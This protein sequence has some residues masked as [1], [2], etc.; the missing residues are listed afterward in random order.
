MTSGPFYCW[1][2]L[3]LKLQI[4]LCYFSFLVMAILCYVAKNSLRGTLIN[5]HVQ[6]LNR[7]LTDWLLACCP[8]DDLLPDWW[9][10]AQLVTCCPTD[11]LFH[12]WWPVALT[13]SIFVWVI[14]DRLT[15]ELLFY[16]YGLHELLLDWFLT[17]LLMICCPT[18]DLLHYWWPAS[19]LM[20]CFL[21]ENLCLT[22]YWLPV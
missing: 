17:T 6:L 21:T 15:H 18:G 20:T 13:F 16:C 12:N 10:V 3:L 19:R 22:Y 11:D 2:F 5:F 4:F 14:T 7:W 8:T 1:H 9:P